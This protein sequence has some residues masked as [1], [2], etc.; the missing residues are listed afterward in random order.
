[1]ILGNVQ[2]L[3]ELCE[4]LAHVTDMEFHLCVLTHELLVETL[5][6]FDVAASWFY[7]GI[8]DELVVVLVEH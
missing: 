6:L 4:P 7:G 1:V 8:I 5:D 2:V 3:P